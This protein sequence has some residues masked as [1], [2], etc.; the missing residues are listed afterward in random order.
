VIEQADGSGIAWEPCQIKLQ[1]FCELKMWKGGSS[2]AVPKTP[3]PTAATLI[4]RDIR[5]PRGF[6]T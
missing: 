4:P 5:P 3:N 1:R 6:S 2:A